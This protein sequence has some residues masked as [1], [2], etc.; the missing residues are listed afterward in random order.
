MPGTIKHYD[1]W[2]HFTTF[3]LT[4]VS[5]QEDFF[6]VSRIK[7]SLFESCMSNLLLVLLIL[8]VFT[9]YIFYHVQSPKLESQSIHLWHYYRLSEREEVEV[10]LKCWMPP[11][12]TLPLKIWHKMTKPLFWKYWEQLKI[13]IWQL[14]LTRWATLPSLDWLTVNLIKYVKNSLIIFGWN[15]F[16]E[17]RRSVLHLMYIEGWERKGLSVYK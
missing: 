14:L 3:Y 12:Q 2:Q 4:T 1:C 6:I 8:F 5:L 11:R 17:K 7:L 10:L 15:K 13:T 16:D 9:L